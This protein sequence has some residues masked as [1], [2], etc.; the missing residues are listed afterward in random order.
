MKFLKPTYDDL[1]E[2]FESAKA[3]FSHLSRSDYQEGQRKIDRAG[4]EIIA[5]EKKTGIDEGRRV[6]EMEKELTERIAFF[7]QA[8]VDYRK[9]NADRD[10]LIDDLAT[11]KIDPD[12]LNEH[13]HR[14]EDW[15]ETIRLTED[16]LTHLRKWSANVADDK[17]KVTKTALADAA[18]RD[19]LSRDERRTFSSFYD[20]ERASRATNEVIE[21]ALAPLP[22]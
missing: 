16:V 5:H 8:L 9:S 13:V 4:V 11:G 21:E 1:I 12:R 7:E 14:V 18:K 20:S 17:A 15:S 3:A 19:P 6:L 2:T 10:Q 22:V